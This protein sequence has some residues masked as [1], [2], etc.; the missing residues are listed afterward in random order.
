MHIKP[1][2]HPSDVFKALANIEAEIEHASD[3]VPAMPKY[4]KPNIIKN[5]PGWYNLVVT[6]LRELR[7]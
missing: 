5:S 1:Y 3:P 7:P 4:D 2:A 6:T